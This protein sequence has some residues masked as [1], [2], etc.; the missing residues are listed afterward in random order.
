MDVWLTEDAVGREVYGI[1]T[2]A[3]KGK[4]V[5]QEKASG[6]FGEKT[7]KPLRWIGDESYVLSA[8]YQ[9]P[10]GRYLFVITRYAVDERKE[11]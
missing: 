7:T 5:C 11:Y 10:G 3:E 2:S 9:D 8:S 6:F 4:E 1:F